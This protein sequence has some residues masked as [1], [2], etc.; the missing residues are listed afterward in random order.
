MTAIIYLQDLRVEK[1]LQRSNGGVMKKLLI[2]LVLL[3]A[4]ISFSQVQELPTLRY[5]KIDTGYI[6]Y[7]FDSNDNVQFVIEGVYRDTCSRPAGT[8]YKVN[9]QAKIVEVVSYEYRYQ[10]PCLDV[11]V[12]HDEVVNLGVVADGNYR[13]VQANGF[14]LGRM[15]ITKATK[16]SPDDYLYAPISQ[17]YLKSRNGQVTVTI[18]GVFSNSCMTLSKVTSQVQPRVISVQ[19]IAEINRSSGGC[20]NGS[21]PFERSIIINNVKAGRYLLHVRSLN[22]KAINNLFDVY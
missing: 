22:G 19:P 5:S 17:A 2:G 9:S 1:L 8:Q 15:I 6:P 7:G 20:V 4:G 11:L 16:A 12:P 10:G 18:S 14:E 3:V 13:V 21:Y